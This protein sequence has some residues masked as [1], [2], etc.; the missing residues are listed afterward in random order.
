[1]EEIKKVVDKYECIKTGVKEV[2]EYKSLEGKIYSTKEECEKADHKFMINQHIEKI[3][4]RYKYRKIYNNLFD[5]EL[6]YIENYEDIR[7]YHKNLYKG[8]YIDTKWK[9]NNEIKNEWIALEKFDGGDDVD[10][11]EYYRVKDIFKDF[12]E[13]KSLISKDDINNGGNKYGI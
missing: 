10:Y 8:C 6:I 11:V 13:L 3:K 7:N 9:Y 5:F 2:I 1:M 4:D 12:E